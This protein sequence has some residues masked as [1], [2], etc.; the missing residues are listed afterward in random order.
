MKK[1]E[2]INIILNDFDFNKIHSVMKFLD[3]RYIY[4]GNTR[5]VPSQDDIRNIARTCLEKVAYS[6]DEIDNFALGGFVAD[7]IENI[8]ELSFV[9]EK[10]NPLSH[11]LGQNK[12]SY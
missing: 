8:L 6:K 12:K 4:S 11:I 10:S 3:W 9:I 2:Q 5:K 7:K 1:E